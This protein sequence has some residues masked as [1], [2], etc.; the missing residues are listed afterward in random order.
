[1]KGNTGTQ[2]LQKI[3][4]PSRAIDPRYTNYIV[5]TA[6]GRIHDGVIAS[7]TPGT[8]TLR[9]GEEEDDTVLR[10]NISSIRASS[11]SLMPEGLE[12]EMSRQDLADVIAF[13][14]GAGLHDH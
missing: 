11:I 5:V 3:L 13:L 14:Q 9:S 4:D 2:L 10:S 12:K 1:M 8:L 7:E 6:D